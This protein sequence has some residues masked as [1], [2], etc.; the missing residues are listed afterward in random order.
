VSSVIGYSTAVTGRL[1][2]IVVLHEG[3]QNRLNEKW[4]TLIRASLNDD[5]YIVT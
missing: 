1:V 4:A 5:R 2:R 3:M